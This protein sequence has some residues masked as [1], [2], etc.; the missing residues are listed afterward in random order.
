[1]LLN[2]VKQKVEDGTFF[3]A[4][5][6]YLSFRWKSLPWSKLQFSFIKYQTCISNLECYLTKGLVRQ[7]CSSKSSKLYHWRSGPQWTRSPSSRYV[8]RMEEYRVSHGKMYFFNPPVESLMMYSILICLKFLKSSHG[9][10]ICIQCNV[11]INFYSKSVYKSSQRKNTKLLKK[12]WP[13]SW[14]YE[15]ILLGISLKYHFYR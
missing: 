3:V 7:T 9:Y 15:I 8:Y 12:D 13:W 6:E 5:S 1:M 2:N 10:S 14:K 4:F 11:C